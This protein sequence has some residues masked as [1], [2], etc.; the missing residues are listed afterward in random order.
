MN[1]RI[2]NHPKKARIPS[3]GLTF[4]ETTSIM[5]KLPFQKECPDIAKRMANMGDL[6]SFQP[7]PTW[8]IHHNGKSAVTALL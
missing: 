5:N 4:T 7:E 1:M 3:T 8:R 2:T 6:G